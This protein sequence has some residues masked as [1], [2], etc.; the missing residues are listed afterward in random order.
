M[1]SLSSKEIIF[2]RGWHITHPGVYRGYS[3]NSQPPPALRFLALCQYKSPHT[4]TSQVPDVCQLWGPC[5]CTSHSLVFLHSST[6][7]PCPLAVLSPKLSWSYTHC[8]LTC[9]IWHLLWAILKCSCPS[10]AHVYSTW[11]QN[12]SLLRKQYHWGHVGLDTLV[13]L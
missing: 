2:S 12:D 1:T 4:S 13:I 3:V 6:S 9:F 8:I 11:F 10:S 7:Q 5:T